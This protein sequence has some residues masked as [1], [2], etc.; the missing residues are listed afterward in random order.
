MGN[1]CKFFDIFLFLFLSYGL[2]FSR[3]PSSKSSNFKLL[4][5]KDNHDDVEN[6]VGTP[7]HSSVLNSYRKIF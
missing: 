4:E 5:Q 1:Y 6:Q 7:N 2:F 3:G